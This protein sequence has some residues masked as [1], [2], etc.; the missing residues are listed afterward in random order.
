MAVFSSRWRDC[1]D[2]MDAFLS[3]TYYLNGGYDNKEGMSKLNSRMEQIEGG[4]R[5]NRIFYLSVPHEALQDVASSL[6]DNA[7]TKKGWNRIIIEK[8]FGF[9][10]VSSQLFTKSLL[11]KYEEK[12]IYRIDHLLGRNLIENLTVLRFSNLVFEPLWSRTY[13]RNVQVILSEDLSMP[14]GRYFDGYGVIR[15][16]VHSH[17]LQTIALLA[18]EPP[19]SLDGEDIRNEKVKVLRSIRELEPSDVILG[20]YK[21]TSQDKVDVSLSSRTPTFFAAALYIDNARWDGVPFMIKAGVGLIKHR[22]EIRIQFNSVPGNLYRERLGHN[23]D[24]TTN[25]LILRDVPDEAILVK[26]NN[27]IPGLGLHLD[28]SELNLL[29]KDKYNVEVPDSYE[30]L[31]LDVIDG[32]NHL[33]LRSDELA[34]AWSIIT[35]VLQWIDQDNMAPELYEL[36]GRG[37]VGSYYLW[38][39]HGVRWADD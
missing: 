34:A 14:R 7:Q 36:G 37:P 2:K 10:A 8:P 19:I 32:D 18:M 12:Q 17:M 33:F 24:L 15:D 16:I 6:G 3:R 31:L 23:T 5:A 30:H 39:K 20:Q 22:L 29:Y 21:A 26:I 35:P 13:I 9:D 11:S 25:E 27:K 28:A 38:A 4:Y 1:G